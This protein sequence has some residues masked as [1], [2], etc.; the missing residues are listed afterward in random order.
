MTM[1]STT[2]DRS[3]VFLDRLAYPAGL[4]FTGVPGDPMLRPRCGRC[5]RYIGDGSVGGIGR[6]ADGYRGEAVCEQCLRRA[7]GL[8]LAARRA[9]EGVSP[10]ED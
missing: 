10:R 2:A 4:A 3:R 6:L 1:A 9:A 7:D 5:C 8:E